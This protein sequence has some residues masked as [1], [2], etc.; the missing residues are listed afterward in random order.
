MF[1]KYIVINETNI[2]VGQSSNGFWYCKELP[3]KTIDELEFKI[4]KVNKILND[5]N[6]NNKND[7]INLKKKKD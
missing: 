7:D 3:S 4:G 1:E 2:I 6:V 5:Y